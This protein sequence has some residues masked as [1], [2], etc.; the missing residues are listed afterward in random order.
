M[1]TMFWVVSYF[2]EE[3]DVMMFKEFGYVCNSWGKT[4]SEGFI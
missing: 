4:P 1:E 3:F 2:I